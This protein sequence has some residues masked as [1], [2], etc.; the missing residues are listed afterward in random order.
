[1]S[2]ADQDMLTAYYRDGISLKGA[3]LLIGDDFDQKIVSPEEA[4]FLNRIDK[5]KTILTQLA[6]AVPDSTG[7]WDY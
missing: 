4:F 3:L 1:M 7:F 2:K 5:D 6:P